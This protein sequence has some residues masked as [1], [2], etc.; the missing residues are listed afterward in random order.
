[1]K[2]AMSSGVRMCAHRMRPWMLLAGVLSL[3]CATT[4]AFAGQA[5]PQ[6][7]PQTL[8]EHFGQMDARLYLGKG[9]RQPLLVGFGGA[10]GGN[11]WASNHWKAQR[12]TFLDQGY[13][14][15]ALGYFGG[16]NTPAHLDRISLDAVHAAIVKAAAQPKVEGRCIALIGGSRGAELALL[17]A[18]KYP[19]IKAVVGLVPGSAVFPGESTNLNTSAFMLHGKP[20]PFV[21]V[22][23]TAIP[24]LIAHN[25][26]G[27]FEKML[28]NKDAVAT[29]AIPVEKINGPVLL[30][31]ATHDELW[32]STRM[33]NN[34]MQRLTRSNFPYIH[35]HEAIPGPHAAPLAHFD[36]VEAFLAAHFLAQRDAGC[37]R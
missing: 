25:L 31:S 8:P 28:A 7:Q 20:V 32:P 37:P 13:A 24:D 22:P 35:V 10:E 17:L 5:P 2:Q 26:Y 16:K 19:D 34:M 23:R 33:S 11:A 27:A 4:V 6:P 21:P 36:D 30:M 29:A 12:Q 9:E 3:L 14:F 15:L 1:M 18:S